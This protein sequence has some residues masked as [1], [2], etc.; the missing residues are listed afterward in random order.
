MIYEERHV[1]LKRGAL[2]D[3][4]RLVLA[5]VWPALAAL[6]ARPLCLL[7]GLI[8]LPALET[9]SFT[10]YRDAAEWERLQLGPGGPAPQGMEA[11]DW[12][13][14][15]GA[16][17]QRVELVAEER[18]RLLRSSEPRPQPQM[19][20]ADRRAVYGMRRFSIHPQDW[21]K[22]VRHSE[23]VW[24]RIETQDARVLGL[25]RDAA[26]TDPLEVTLLTGYHGPAH[27]EATRGGDNRPR[28]FPED[29]WERGRQSSAARNAITLRSYVCLMTAH[30]PD[31]S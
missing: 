2:A 5:Q 19:P 3:Y 11:G 28:G 29:L 12:K 24:A 16:L 17:A 1:M 7:S 27:W 31:E 14:L 22:F 21:R 18:T 4:R 10:G 9:Y 25:F 23:G 26:T 6:G 13:K 20:A 15:C 30:W 8:G